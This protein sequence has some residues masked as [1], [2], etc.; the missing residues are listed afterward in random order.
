MR[1]AP[2]APQRGTREAW[3]PWCSGRTTTTRAAKPAGWWHGSP[4]HGLTHHPHGN[5]TFGFH[6]IPAFCTRPL[7][8]FRKTPTSSGI[9]AL[10]TDCRPTVTVPH[11]KG[12]PPVSLTSAYCPVVRSTAPVASTPSA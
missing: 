8:Y 7:A 1:N 10:V 2:P 11:G 5:A 12:L 4:Y 6:T 3:G 9:A